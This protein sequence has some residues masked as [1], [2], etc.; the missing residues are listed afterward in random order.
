MNAEQ[1]M[2]IDYSTK[3]GLCERHLVGRYV[4]RASVPV[5]VAQFLSV[6]G[7]DSPV[8]IFFLVAREEGCYQRVTGPIEKSGR[9]AVVLSLRYPVPIASG[10]W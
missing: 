10:N 4:K 8:F 3:D 6:D 9:Q 5:T 1:S 2:L 7:D